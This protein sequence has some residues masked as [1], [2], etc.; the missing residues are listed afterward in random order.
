MRA[1]HSPH[2][3]APPIGFSRASPS[4]LPRKPA[5]HPRHVVRS[6]SE[7]KT[8][9]YLYGEWTHPYFISIEEYD[10]IMQRTNKL[11]Q[12]RPAGVVRGPEAG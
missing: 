3:I 1:Q 5:P 2:V 10:R 12:V 7:R 9:D 4:E 11:E 6:Q 8:L